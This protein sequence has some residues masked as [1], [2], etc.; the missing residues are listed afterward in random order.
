MDIDIDIENYIDIVSNIY[1]DIDINI[2]IDMDIDSYIDIDSN[3][4]TD[5]DPNFPGK[6]LL[7]TRIFQECM[8]YPKL[9]FITF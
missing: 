8:P 6:V 5:I 3:I 1:F 2:D 4:D 7:L 9:S